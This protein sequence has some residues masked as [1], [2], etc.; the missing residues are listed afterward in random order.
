MIR[1]SLSHPIRV[2]ALPV[3]S[4]RLGLTF[5]P[6]K[7]GDSLSG[8]VW[9]RNLDLDLGGLKTWGADLIVTLMERHEFGLL[10]VPDLPER[11]VAQ[12][13][14][15][16]HLPIRDVDVPA[17][18]FDALWP[19]VL[20][21]ILARLRAG[22]NVVLHCRGGLGRTGLVAAMILIETGLDPEEAIRAVRA[23]RPS[24]IETVGQERYVRAYQ[25]TQPAAE[26]SLS[27]VGPN[28]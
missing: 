28:A 14:E 3:L 27:T 13:I 1:T 24:A 12:G 9:A 7:H 11:I 26:G 2:D 15:W 8:P 18:A 20:A 19:S 23:V 10:R 16:V 21:D 5:C 25:A 17:A 22:G 4:G 6:G